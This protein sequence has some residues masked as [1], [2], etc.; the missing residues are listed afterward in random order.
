MSLIALHYELKEKIGSGNLGTVY[1][2]EDIATKKVFQI[3]I[4]DKISIEDIREKLN[5]EVMNEITK[6]S[7]QNLIKIYDYGI[8][9]NNLYSISEYFNGNNLL[10]FILN[11]KNKKDFFQIIIQTCYAL[12]H[13]YS[14][15]I[16]HKDLKLENVLFK[17]VEGKIIVKVCDYGFNKV[18][19]QTEAYTEVEAVNQSYLSPELLQGDSFSIKSDLY[20]LGIILYYIT[21]GT[22]PFSMDE[23]R[24]ITKK[25]SPNIIPQFPSKI[26]PIVEEKMEDLI[27]RLIEFNPDLRISNISE[28][29]KYI[30]QSQTK[31]FPISVEPPLVKQIKSKPIRY[32]NKSIMILKD[33][34]SEAAEGNGKIVFVLGEKGVGKRET[35]RYLKWHLLSEDYYIF[36]YNCSKYHRDPF[37]LISK[38]IYLSHGKEDKQK[39]EE[40]ASKKFSEFLF[41]SEEKSLMITEDKSD[42]LKDFTLIKSYIYSSSKIK[43][44]VF[45]ICNF[46]M[47]EKDT[48]DFLEFISKDIYGHP[49]LIVVCTFNILYAESIENAEQIHI[50]F[51]SKAET[52][53]YL[54]NLL[55]VNY[56]QKF[57]YQIYYLSNG[58][59]KFIKYLLISLIK[60][61]IIF[62]NNIWNFNI[63]IT[64][65]TLPIEINNHIKLKLNIV[66][67]NIKNKLSKLAVLQVPLS[68]EIIKYI[69][70]SDLFKESFLFLD[71]YKEIFFFIQKC[72]KFEILIKDEDYIKEGYYKFV[73]PAIKNLLF[74][75]SS[76]SEKKAISKKVVY[77]F[78][79]KVVT[80]PVIMDEIISHCEIIGDYESIVDYQMTKTKY[81]FNKNDFLYAWDVC[82]TAVKNLE[83]LNKKVSNKKIQE[84]IKFL[85]KISIMIEKCKTMLKVYNLWQ[86]SIDSDFEILWFYSRLLLKSNMYNQSLKALQLAEEIASPQ[87]MNNVLISKIEI[88]ISSPNFSKDESSNQI[89]NISV[90]NLSQKQKVAFYMQKA[91]FHY[92]YTEY[93][94]AIDNWKIAEKISQKGLMLF[95]LGRIYKF[96]ADAYNT[97]NKLQ[98]AIKNYEKASDIS[99]KEGDVFNLANIYSSWG[100]VDIKK[101]ILYQGIKK[102]KKALH[103]FVSIQYHPG[104]GAVNLILAQTKYKL[105]KFSEADTYFKDGLKVAHEIK[106]SNLEKEILRRYSF[107]KL[108]I[109]SPAIFLDFLH[110]NYAEYFTKGK[111]TSI[112]SYLKNYIFFLVQ[113]GKDNYIENIL[114]QIEDQQIA[115]NLEKE[116]IYQVHGW[117]E[118]SKGNIP[119]AINY[120]KKS[121]SISKNNENEYAL[122]INYFNVSD[123]YCIKGNIN[124]AEIYCDL[125]KS[126]AFK[127]NFLRWQ[128]K[129]RVCQSKLLLKKQY[130]NLRVIL[131]DLLLAEKIAIEM[132]DWTLICQINLLIMLIYRILRSQQLEKNYKRKFANHIKLLTKDLTEEDKQ[133]FKDRFYYSLL[134]SNTK[135]RELIT[136]RI[137]TSTIK[138]QQK[139][140]D[141][142]QLTTSEQIKFYLK[143]Y[144]KEIIGID[145]F[146]ILLYEKTKTDIEFWLNNGFPEGSLSSEHEIYIEKL[147]REMKQLYYKVGKINYC[148]S[149]LTIK[150]EIIGIIIL[151]DNGELPFTKTEKLIIKL[152]SFYLTI[153]LK[154]IGEYKEVVEQSRQFSNLLIISRDILQIMDLQKLENHIALNALRLTD[155]ER[156]FLITLDENNNFIFNVALMKSGDRIEKS[157]LEINKAILKDVYE[158][159]IPIISSSKYKESRYT[160]NSINPTGLNSIYCAP[161][162]V[163][164]KIFGFLYLDNLGNIQK[165]LNFNENVL[166]IFKLTSETAI[167]NSLDYRELCRAN[168]KLLKV[169][170]ERADFINISS[171]EFNTPIQILKGYLGILKDENISDTTK[172]NT[173]RIMENNVNRLV[174]SINNILQMNALEKDTSKLSKE[175]IDI[176]DILKIVYDETKVFSDRRKQKL[177]LKIPKDIKPVYAERL[178]LINAVK[179]LVLNA[180]KFTEDYGEIVIG[181]R[182]SK[183]KN[184][185]IN[186]ENSV[187]IY[188]KDNGIGIPSY[189]LDNIFKEF[190]EVADIKAHHSGLTK[191]KSSG[192]GLG[193]P[194]TKSIVELLGGKIWAESVKDEGSTFFIGLPLSN[195]DN[196]NGKK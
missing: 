52:N 71:S 172:A 169:D 133:L 92:T 168:E 195:N 176:S 67:L 173:L 90:D 80:K 17:K 24:L 77:Y 187:I 170:Q 2:L 96:I 5:P 25:N 138:L 72:E 123:S 27:F 104:I 38:E 33:F 196:N 165:T 129:A 175:L 39:F 19:S 159:C 60:N 29:I 128:N 82:I 7:H 14:H 113:T 105:G 103:Y 87:E 65:M 107:L 43:P 183:F 147:K 167:K 144:V 9:Q 102:I 119:A 89:N 193:L 26:N 171:H 46:D 126:I 127:N 86:Q 40:K 59:Q 12:D 83:K 76:Q 13:L 155:A 74:A 131:R 85:M 114:Q 93:K 106:D 186:D 18:I 146:G 143:K 124:Q 21:V 150:N 70:S 117:V 45:F 16:I 48:M 142:L 75:K 97:Q 100:M 91:K 68:T 156:G 57:L 35:I 177:V 179:N 8:Y 11:N 50:P 110:N 182:K 174:H 81:F 154:K 118:R 31:Q 49:I 134:E 122:M 108:K 189:E 135:I 30:N 63:N 23:I 153:I 111:I 121:A 98:K 161:L 185:R 55:M 34:V 1:K 190:Y 95:E 148:L 120:F 130:I 32:H 194:V 41:R 139:F 79:D 20:S 53:K 94:Q 4:F 109:S 166:E 157:N 115:Y 6:L 84:C 152:S 47:A 160:N 58:N 99:E 64:K 44:I 132:K 184:E 137:H 42:L 78:K 149:P 162:K 180:I 66:P 116:F 141:L 112:N 51:L 22:F 145:K 15:N 56:P 181:V 151:S 3:K 178:C 164:N 61:K 158:T 101:G 192:L 163:N 188:V 62:D 136:P 37:F 36:N 69:L 73:Y 10:N 88:Y 140:F 54:N 28:I 191:F 125:A